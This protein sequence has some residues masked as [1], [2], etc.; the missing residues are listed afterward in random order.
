MKCLLFGRFLVIQL[1]SPPY[2]A[3]SKRGATHCYC[4]MLCKSVLIRWL[5]L[6]NSSDTQWRQFSKRKHAEIWALSLSDH[7]HL[8]SLSSPV[9]F[10]FRLFFWLGDMP[11]YPAA[12]ASAQL[13]A[14]MLFH[15]VRW[16]GAQTHT[17]TC[18]S[19]SFSDTKYITTQKMSKLYV[20]VSCD[21][22][23]SPV[24]TGTLQLV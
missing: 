12:A 13:L 22:I 16:A 4:R 15:T 6:T 5:F 9:H 2:L 10:M 24:E 7:W 23:F 11:V 1:L 20:F 21:V 18:F 14:V 17:C 8:G 19:L 3:V